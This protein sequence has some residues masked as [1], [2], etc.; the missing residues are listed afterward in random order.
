MKVLLKSFLLLAAITSTLQ[1]S[2]EVVKLDLNKVTMN[3]TALHIFDN[4]IDTMPQKAAVVKLSPEQNKEASQLN[5][6]A[7]KIYTSIL[8][9]STVTKIRSVNSNLTFVTKALNKAQKDHKEELEKLKALKKG[10]LKKGMSIQTMKASDHLK[11]KRLVEL[12]ESYEQESNMAAY[13]EQSLKDRI[14]LLKE[15][16]GQYEHEKNDLVALIQENKKNMPLSWEQKDK[17]KRKAA[18]ES[19]NR[20]EDELIQKQFEDFFGNN[21]L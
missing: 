1:A 11:G 13:K 12:H 15:Q 8:L 6:E 10:M 16:K 7:V 17:I 19:L 2:G 3:T 9:N 21:A 14:S 5:R 20:I 4:I 18:V